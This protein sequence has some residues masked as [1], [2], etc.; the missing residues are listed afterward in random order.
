MKKNIIIIVLSVVALLLAGTVGYLIAEKVISNK[1]ENEAI[2]EKDD[3][4]KGNENN[5]QQDIENMED[6]V[7]IQKLDLSKCLNTSYNYSNS[8]DKEGDY[9]LSMSINS[10]KRSITLSIYW[11]KFGHLSTA[12]TW[13]DSI[14]KYQI[15]GFEKNVVNTFVGD[16]GQSTK[17][18]VLFYLMEDGTVEY[19]PMF[20]LKYDSYNNSYYVMNYTYEYSVD[21][22]ITG[23]HFEPKGLISDVE[24]VIKLYNTDVATSGA[25]HRSTIG[26]KADGSFYD[27]GEI[28]MSEKR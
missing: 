20:E 15:T 6:N 27:L 7:V 9:G 1:Y 3:E 16:I 18:I 28:I 17:G 22:R 5:T 19:T 14:E 21:G 26:A 8:S 4:V 2:D 11:S 23:Q 25:G 12:S 13:P 24:N 10:N